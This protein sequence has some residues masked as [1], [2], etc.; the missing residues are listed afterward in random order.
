MAGGEAEAD[1]LP[2]LA[3]AEDKQEAE[4]PALADLELNWPPVGGLSWIRQG[5]HPLGWPL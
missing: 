3:E 5:C 4:Q 2:A 1:D